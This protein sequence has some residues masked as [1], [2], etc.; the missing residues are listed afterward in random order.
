MTTP[1]R[2]PVVFQDIHNVMT[3]FNQRATIVPVATNAYIFEACEEVFTTGITFTTSAGVPTFYS[4]EMA[5][6]P[7]YYTP[8][9]PVDTYQ[10]RVAGN[11]FLA[12]ANSVAQQ[13]Y[14][15]AKAADVKTY[16]VT[17][18]LADADSVTGLQNVHK[19]GRPIV[20]HT[21]LP[22]GNPPPA[23]TGATADGFEPDA[24]TKNSYAAQ[25]PFLIVTTNLLRLATTNM[26]TG[27]NRWNIPV[28]FVTNASGSGTTP[29][30]TTLVIQ[31]EQGALSDNGVT[32][33]IGSSSPQ[34]LA[35]ASPSKSLV[36]TPP[37]SGYAPIALTPAG[38][39]AVQAI[40]DEA[41]ATAYASSSPTVNIPFNT[42]DF[43][44]YAPSLSGYP[45][46]A[47]FVVN[48]DAIGGGSCGP[49]G[50]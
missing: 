27:K 50:C 6:D 24:A 36:T 13:R 1:T 35:F 26:A 42:I 47:T 5:A 2:V 40:A 23:L 34:V 29:S 11:T 38:Q 18:T 21:G 45:I 39:A 17:I 41:F 4:F 15:A 25:N 9:D 44:K 20:K 28:A 30:S 3:A 43:E 14:A 10:Y 46:T 8:G 33:P 37:S 22:G 7:A 32:V 49:Y 31:G 12:S 19:I 48:T 16:T